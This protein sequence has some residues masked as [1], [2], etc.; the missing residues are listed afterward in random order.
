MG[1]ETGTYISDFVITNPPDSDPANQLDDHIRLVK[2]LVTATFPGA[3]P[4]FY[5]EPVTA[6]SAQIDSWDAR[7][8]TMEGQPT[9]L[10]SPKSGM[11]TMSANQTYSV[12]GLGFQPN[13]IIA[14]AI[15]YWGAITSSYHT[16]GV[17]SWSSTDDD[18]MMAA[19]ALGSV[20][21]LST[22]TTLSNMFLATIGTTGATATEVAIGNI[23]SDGFDLSFDK[24]GLGARVMYL[25]FQ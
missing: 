1:L 20:S 15:V 11:V 14:F 19:V 5:D 22:V 4:D 21:A 7:L 10:A 6:T 3:T 12:T 24:F 18:K 25:A 2:S 8:T 9:T 23:G 13:H 16:I 17:T